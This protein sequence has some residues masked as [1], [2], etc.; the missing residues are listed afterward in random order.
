MAYLT[1]ETHLVE[2]S[3][4]ELSNSVRLRQLLGIV[5]T[6]GNRLNTAGKGKKKK[7][8]AF[9]L[10]SLLKLNQAKAFDKKTTFLQ[11][12]VLIVQRNN[13]LLLRFKDDLPTVFKA[14]KVFWDQCISDLE[15]V[16]NQLENVRK[17][18]LYQAHH[19]AKFRR[20]KKRH[21]EGGEDD[22]ES[23]SDMSLSLEEE[24][25]ALRST[26]IGL[27]TLSA[28]KKV[29]F[30]RDRVEGTKVKFQ[31]V[32]EY[33][34]EDEKNMQ[35]HDLFN[36]I[37]K[38]CRDFDKA[39][40]QVFAEEKKKKREERKRQNATTNV[41]TPNKTPI[42]K[43]PQHSQTM[44]RASSMQPN[45]SRLIDDMKRNNAA[46]SRTDAP[47]QQPE[48][49]R[50]MTPAA[51]AREQQVKGAHGHGT[52]PNDPSFN[53]RGA[54]Y[55]TSVGQD[56]PATKDS[57]NIPIQPS[58]PK[59]LLSVP[60]L[61]DTNQSSSQN[62]V[63]QQHR[64]ESNEAAATPIR[65]SQRASHEISS[66]S[67]PTGDSNA[68]LSLSHQRNPQ[69]R[70]DLEEVIPQGMQAQGRIEH[71]DTVS[72]QV[73]SE[74]QGSTLRR[75]ARIRRA[76]RRTGVSPPEEPQVSWHEADSQHMS[77]EVPTMDRQNS[78]PIVT[79]NPSVDHHYSRR[80][81]APL[82]D[83]QVSA[84]SANKDLMRN[85]LRSKRLMERKQRVMGRHSPPPN[86][87]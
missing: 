30:L 57:V 36:I 18:A 12:I 54:A 61:P 73:T 51:Q 52:H 48:P 66:Q 64:T 6:F 5:L 11:Y 40:E 24:V 9:T 76:P 27:F 43:P 53:R 13:E 47:A 59:Q 7:A 23:L 35:P 80:S 70:F 15:E 19:A 34:G 44:L 32:L 68:K 28:I 56:P 4:D 86:P 49:R 78:A 37:V 79:S 84:H 74:H 87:V 8:G 33:F 77:R 3:C 17:I 2:T 60:I 83:T 10:D 29:S 85:K 45:A 71:Q 67:S 50:Q 62:D 39:K 14:D 55:P 46:F 82:V 1:P 81:S 42:E 69:E 21:H 65:E 22:E 38:F 16:E 72:T 31:K 20:K 41:Q 63:D 58:S 26:P 25:D 75:K